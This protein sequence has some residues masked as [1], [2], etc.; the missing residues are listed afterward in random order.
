MK[1]HMKIQ[2]FRDLY[3]ARYD[4]AA[5]DFE[6]AVLWR[7][8]NPKSLPLARMLW[9]MN[10]EYFAPDLELIRH[11]QDVTSLDELRGEFGAFCYH[12]PNAG[13]LRKRLKVRLSGQSLTNLAARLFR[14]TGGMPGPACIT[15]NPQAWPK[16]VREEAKA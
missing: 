9:R 16:P 15:R 5:G 10:P 1:L 8:L 7:C 4:C 14:Q 2:S 3:C 12:H 11:V 6:T 13:W